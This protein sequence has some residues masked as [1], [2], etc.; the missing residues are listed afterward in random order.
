MGT[1]RGTKDNFDR[2]ADR[3]PPA[4]R[5]KPKF[6]QAEPARLRMAL[7]AY[8]RLQGVRI[9]I[10]NGIKGIARDYPGY[11]KKQVETDEEAFKDPIKAMETTFAKRIEALIK[12]HPLAKW[13]VG[14]VKG[15]AWNLTGQLIGLIGDISTFPNVSHLWSYAGLRPDQRRTAGV[16]SDWNPDLKRLM[17]NIGT[18]LLKAGGYYADV[19][20]H[21]RSR[22]D[23]RAESFYRKL[24]LRLGD[25]H[26]VSRRL[27]AEFARAEALKADNVAEELKSD[28][29][30]GHEPSVKAMTWNKLQGATVDGALALGFPAPAKRD[31]NALIEAIKFLSDKLGFT[32]VSYDRQGQKVA[33]LATP[34]ITPLHRYSRAI[35][36]LS[37]VFLEHVFNEWSKIIGRPATKPWAFG[38]GGHDVGSYISPPANRDAVFGGDS[39]AGKRAIAAS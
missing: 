8:Y 28:E 23:A 5:P 6:E 24:M 36:K 13:I 14:H 38:P 19:Y 15:M 33:L 32:S 20:R 12:D 17:Y 3:P 2:F 39:S 22:E 4:A 21:Y 29:D 30:E 7:G 31:Y 26:D 18:S 11:T 10:S 9:A 25:D 35:R 1:P 34:A 16:K 27:R 37:K